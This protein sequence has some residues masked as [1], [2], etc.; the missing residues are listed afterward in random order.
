MIIPYKGKVIDLN[1]P[2]LDSGKR[3]SRI[4]AL[5]GFKTIQGVSKTAAGEKRRHI[6]FSKLCDADKLDHRLNIDISNE[7]H[8]AGYGDVA[9]KFTQVDSEDPQGENTTS[10]IHPGLFKECL[11]KDESE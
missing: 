6:K 10:S 4:T 11:E 5:A 1:Q 8:K 2:G 3:K 9:W 7:F